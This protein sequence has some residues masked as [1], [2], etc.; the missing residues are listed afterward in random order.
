MEGETSRQLS[1]SFAV[2]INDKRTL[3]RFEGV[4]S[5]HGFPF[6]KM[7]ETGYPAGV[8]L[9]LVEGCTLLYRTAP[10]NN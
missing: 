7:K 5:I 6:P 2:F 3:L 10:T 1:Q 8:T 4:Q 9:V